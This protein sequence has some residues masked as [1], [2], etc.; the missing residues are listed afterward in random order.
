M[1]GL[2]QCRGWRGETRSSAQV[3]NRIRLDLLYIRTWSLW[4]DLRILGETVLHVI[5]PPK[6]AN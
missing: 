6:S 3:N 5:R 1:T 2:A 4:L